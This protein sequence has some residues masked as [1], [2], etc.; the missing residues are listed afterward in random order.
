[1]NSKRWNGACNLLILLIC[2]LDFSK[3]WCHVCLFNKLDC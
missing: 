1:L 3:T 2:G